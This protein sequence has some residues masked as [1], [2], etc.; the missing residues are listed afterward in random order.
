MDQMEANKQFN[1]LIEQVEPIFRQY[2][3]LDINQLQQQFNSYYQVLANLTE[4]RLRKEQRLHGIKGSPILMLVQN[5]EGYKAG[6]LGFKLKNDDLAL[7]LDMEDKHEKLKKEVQPQLQALQDQT[8]NTDLL[9]EQQQKE[10]SSILQSVKKMNTLLNRNVL[11]H[12]FTQ[13]QKLNKAAHQVFHSQK[14][15]F[16]ASDYEWF[17]PLKKN[18]DLNKQATQLLWNNMLQ[19]FQYWNE[20]ASAYL[21]RAQQLINYFQNTAVDATNDDQIIKLNELIILK[22]SLDII[23]NIYGYTEKQAKNLR[24]AFSN[25][26]L[27]DDNTYSQHHQTFK[28]IFKSNTYKTLGSLEVVYE[29]FSQ[30]LPDFAQK[31]KPLRE[32]LDQIDSKRRGSI[33]AA[34]NKQ[35]SIGKGVLPSVATISQRAQQAITNQSDPQ[36]RHDSLGSNPSDP[37]NVAQAS[38]QIS[39]AITPADLASYRQAIATE[40]AKI[41]PARRKGMAVK[42]DN[43]LR[44]STVNQEGADLDPMAWE[45]QSSN[46]YKSGKWQRIKSFF[47]KLFKRNSRHVSSTAHMHSNLG[48]SNP[49]QTSSGTSHDKTEHDPNWV[50]NPLNKNIADTTNGCAYQPDEEDEQMQQQPE[51]NN[52]QFDKKL[53]K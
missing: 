30:S 5:L 42:K 24:G 26:D 22:E 16:S 49:A 23:S 50:S 33:Q 14:Q 36:A 34:S 8:I 20:Q 25:E 40:Y 2:S 15:G 13:A 48:E 17:E 47:A 45:N 38:D 4:Q 44:Q 19:R 32:Y 29:D 43:P 3:F 41:F 9:T 10:L 27:I 7:M 52:T 6:Q 12:L 31:I 28:D 39:S 51:V 46:P 37:E 1:Q 53:K 11:T 18:I 35:I 21:N